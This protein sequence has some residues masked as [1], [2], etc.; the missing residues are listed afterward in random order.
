[1][2]ARGARATGGGTFWPSPGP[3]TVT[4]E[5]LRP[6][7]SLQLSLRKCAEM[8]CKHSPVVLPRIQSPS[9]FQEYCVK[10]KEHL[11]E[12][13][14]ENRGCDAVKAHFILIHPVRQNLVTEKKVIRLREEGKNLS[15]VQEAVAVPSS[16]KRRQ[17][18]K[19]EPRAGTY[20]L[21]QHLPSP[22]HM[23]PPRACQER[24]ARWV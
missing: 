10:E 5:L 3:R 7:G 2:G 6:R 17:L 22:G 23:S 18:Q 13:F 24:Q 20:S 11:T 1:M 8:S 19:E 15:P 14:L 21:G 4:Q 12:R 16:G 9:R